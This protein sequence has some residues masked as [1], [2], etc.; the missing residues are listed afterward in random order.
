MADASIALQESGIA[1]AAEQERVCIARERRSK[2]D[3]ARERESV[4]VF[5]QSK[6]RHCKRVRDCEDKHV[7]FSRFASLVFVFPLPFPLYICIYFK[8]N[9][10][11]SNFSA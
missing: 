11:D 1:R 8:L 10:R 2:S 4:C 9:I 6:K 3:G 7:L 5:L